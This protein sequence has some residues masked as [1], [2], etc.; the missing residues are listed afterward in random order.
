MFVNTKILTPNVQ[1]TTALGVKSLK[2]VLTHLL[3]PVFFTVAVTLYGFSKNTFSISD[4]F[5]AFFGGVLFYSAPYIVWAIF[6]LLSKPKLSVIHAGYVGATVSLVAI[7]SFWLLPPDRSG[8]PLQWAAYWPLA[9]VLIIIFAGV[10]H[11]F[12]RIKSS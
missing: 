5:V 12:T 2:T 4:G 9:L 1:Q 8:L 6:H 7:S 3:V 11:L 10:I